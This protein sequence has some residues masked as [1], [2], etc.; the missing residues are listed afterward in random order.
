MSNNLQKFF[1]LAIVQVA[2]ATVSFAQLLPSERN[3]LMHALEPYQPHP[4]ARSCGM[5]DHMVS[6]LQNME[7]Q[8]AF[9][10][11]LTRLQSVG[12]PRAACSSPVK[13]PVAVH[14]VGLTSPNAS[15]LTTLA[16]GQIAALNNDYAGTNSDISIWNGSAASYF[17]GVSNGNSCLQFEIAT[18]NHPAGTGL[19]DGDLAITINQVT[20]DFSST[21]ANYLNIFVIK[22]TG[23]LGY[24]PLGGRGNGDGVVVDAAAFGV[25]GSCGEVY[26]TSP[27]NK[28]RTLTHELGHYLLLDHI[29]GGGSSCSDSDNVADTPNQ[30][31]EY[32]GCPSLGAASCGSTDMHMSYMDYT[33]DACMYMFSAGQVARMEAYTATFLSRITSNAA[34]VLGTGGGS[35]PAPTCNDGIQNQGE[36][37]VDCG[38]PCTA[39]ATCNDGIRNQGE[40]GI[41]CG[42]PCTAC[43]TCNDGIQNQ[44]ETGIDCGGPCT[45]CVSC[46][47][48]IQNQGETGVDCGGPCAPC[49]TCTDGI[50]NQGETGVDCGGPCTPCPSCEDG[51]LNQGE[52]GV[53]CGGP[54]APCPTCEDGIQNQG[55][56]GVDC[57]GP[58]AP[59]PTCDDGI[60]N[61]GEEGI[62]CGGP[63]SAICPTCDDGV[64]NGTEEG[65]DCGGPCEVCPSCEI[66]T[67]LT[68]S[69]LEKNRVTLNWDTV[70]NVIHYV[71]QIRLEGSESW[72]SFQ[73]Q[74]NSLTI[75]GLSKETI[76]EWHVMTDCERKDS[77]WSL[78]C[79][80]NS[81]DPNS[82]S[83]EEP[84]VTATCE[85]G[86]QNGDET[87]VDCGGACAPCEQTEPDPTCEDGV[88][89]GDE[90][91]ID[92]GGSCAPCDQTEPDPTCEDGIQNGDE[93]GIDCG[94]ACDPCPTCDDGIQ[95]GNEEGVDCGGTCA[96]CSSCQAP[97][98][99]LVTN[100]ARGRVT[101][102][103][104]AVEGANAY[105]IQIRLL[106][107]ETWY[108]FRT[109]STSQTIRGLSRNSDYE[110]RLSTECSDETSNWSAICVFNSDDPD[111]GQCSTEPDPTCDD[112]I[113][114][115]DETGVDCG[116]SCAPCEQTEPEP[117]CE[118][119][120][121]NGDET[122]VDCGGSCTP[123]GQ[124]EPDPTCEDGIQNGD[125]TGV[126]CG[127]SC[128]PCGQT[129]PDPTCED[130]IQNG[131]ETGVDCG[132]SCIP[133]DDTCPTPTDLVQVALVTNAILS[134]SGFSEADEY[135]LQIRLSGAT[136]WTTYRSRNNR[137]VVSRLRR[138][139]TYEWRVQT[140]CGENAS[141][142]S[143]AAF[144]VAG[145]S[146]NTSGR[147]GA[148]IN[149]GTDFQMYPNPVSDILTLLIPVSDSG[150]SHIRLLDLNG[151]IL[152]SQPMEAGM[153]TMELNVSGLPK[154]LYF[155]K[156]ESKGKVNLK[157]LV[158]Q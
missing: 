73:S 18:R 31:D 118:D 15:C 93:T 84:P 133:C 55:E 37:G 16:I 111:S 123:C 54:C 56:T 138:G 22:N 41:D 59:C 23:Y 46:T 75:R 137:Y 106:G 128:T 117:T 156:L 102:N 121:Q 9:R 17:P 96:P 21:W 74:N 107:S 134:W 122:G 131:D 92:C 114:N 14:F 48:G 152:I 120:I 44:G 38:G 4:E 150:V 157:R 13:V 142:W 51:I 57:G 110:W 125:E 80:F 62:D 149:S 11:K 63:C 1:L 67:N 32:Y 91:G 26:S 79:S 77:D 29:W 53:D 143:A 85:D 7:Y 119:G 99:L 47:D 148:P 97:D 25:G 76:Y 6:L 81:S 153:R 132:G 45:A 89:N 60:Q 104:N 95:N 42:G 78:L 66:P 58:C 100:F 71:V 101:L 82:G 5:N 61:Q 144:F 136:D 68:I 155:V 88:Q 20:G 113:Q 158:I 109:L 83:C 135:L 86:I 130:G 40:T 24:S 145:T 50:Q 116:G 69:G 140:V 52:E 94:G 108:D 112:G 151:K 105:N 141:T 30:D 124:T 36:T 39:C 12:G 129:E 27:Y 19:S 49:G 72:Y 126:D 2:F 103:W 43:A 139:E 146:G 35:P 8:L 64:Q 28:G 10:E 147:K 87:G 127:G 65:I 90:T 33:N 70:A 98:G 115:G 34:N 3:L 154:G